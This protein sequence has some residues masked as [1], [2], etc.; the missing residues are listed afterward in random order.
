MEIMLREKRIVLLILLSV[1]ILR[2][3]ASSFDGYKVDI[4]TFKAWSIA[5]VNV[6]ISN[7]Y[8]EVWCDYP[9]F[10][11]YILGIIGFVSKFLSL[12]DP[13]F[14][15]LIKLPANVADI[16]IA[17]ALYEGLR[18]EVDF[19]VSLLGMTFYALNPGLIFNGA[20]WGQVDAVSTLFVFLSVL[21]LL[22][23]KPEISCI[24]LV[25][26]ILTKLICAIIIPLIAFLIIKKYD[27]KRILLCLCLSILTFLLISLPFFCRNPLEIFSIYF[28]GYE[29][30][31]YNSL[32]AFN[33]WSL[34]G[35]WKPDDTI[36]LLFSFKTWGMILFFSLIIYVIYFL[37]KEDL[38]SINFAS[39]LLFFGFYMFFTRIHERYLFT[40]FAFL[41]VCAW[42]DRRFILPYLILS[43]T[44]LVN[45]WYALILLNA[46]QFMSANSLTYSMTILN[47]G[48]LLSSIGK[49]YVEARKG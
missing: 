19:R 31:R 8:S 32:S 9:P 7:F 14:T 21:F 43:I 10:Y 17:Y 16:L 41:A 47:V 4:G 15:I 40:A 39:Y 25:V 30:Y 45:L 34:F 22:R 27:V 48:V 28:K 38:F 5:V 23:E 24:F 42:L 33:L 29:Y 6:G 49:W 26:S 35:F 20:I 37:R 44:Y 3:V 2:I 36:F 1:F 13:Y 11:I 12:S 46:D 18:R